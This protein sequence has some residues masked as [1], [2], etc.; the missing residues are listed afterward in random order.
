MLFIEFMLANMGTIV[1][2]LILALLV[3]A[4]VIASVRAKRAGKSSCGGGCSGCPMS[5]K[6]HGTHNKKNP[7]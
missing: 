4:I 2:A 6:C 5:G 1:I 7:E 3:A